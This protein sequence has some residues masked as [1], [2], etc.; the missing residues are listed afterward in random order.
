MTKP[1]TIREIAKQAN[2]SIGTVDRVLH[3]RGRV[4]EETRQRVLKIAREGNYSSNIMARHLRLNKTYTIQVILPKE[5]SYW[6]TLKDGIEDG[7]LEYERMG[8]ATRYFFPQ[9]APDQPGNTGL[10]QSL[11]SDAD[12]FIIAPS[13]FHEDEKALLKLKATKKPFVFVDS[14]IDNTG[15]L[16]F[17][18]QDA[19]SSGVLGARLLYDNYLPA[20]HIFL[21]TFGKSDL[22]EASVIDR[23][24]GFNSFFTNHRIANVSFREI[25]LERDHISLDDFSREVMSQDLPVHIFIPNSKSYLL[26]SHLPK[27]KHSKQIRVVGYDL[28]PSNTELLQQ[29]SIDFLI[30]QK[31]QLQGYLGIQSLFKHLILK[32]DLPKNQFMPIDIITREN[33]KYGQ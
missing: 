17:I 9:E 26:A 29:G 13:V 20:Y 10:D 16:S 14:K 7:R 30:H 25:N 8:F 6:Q 19:F 2:V 18:G 31:P 21:L 11:E 12:G 23:T 3:Q 5:N 15:Y 28:L 27:I 24:A 32:A 4:A 1:I 22:T 33:V